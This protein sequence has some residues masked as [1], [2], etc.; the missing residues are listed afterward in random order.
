M[1]SPDFSPF[2]SAKSLFFSPLSN[3]S[4]G[5]VEQVCLEEKTQVSVQRPPV[6]FTGTASQ[7]DQQQLNLYTFITSWISVSG[8]NEWKRVLKTG[9]K[10]EFGG[11]GRW[12]NSCHSEIMNLIT[13]S[14]LSS[15]TIIIHPLPIYCT[16]IL[17]IHLNN[18]MEYI[19]KL[20]YR[21]KR[22]RAP[23]CTSQPFNKC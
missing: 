11:R 13:N 7:A 17:P 18:E 8:F 9:K 1:F 19:S 23:P 5:A 12:L 4:A 6:S 20:I 2:R 3:Y 22:S 14:E 16:G 21:G 10:C 15:D